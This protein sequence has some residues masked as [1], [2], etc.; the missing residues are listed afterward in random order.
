MYGGKGDIIKWYIKKKNES[1]LSDEVF[2]RVG[3][4]Y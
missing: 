1:V 3:E 2:L 4:N